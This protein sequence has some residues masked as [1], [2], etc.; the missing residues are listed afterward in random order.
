MQTICLFGSDYASSRDLHLALKRLL[1][2]PDYYGLNADALNDC[3]SDFGRCPALWFRA[4]GPDEVVSAL[5][6]IARVFG[7]NG[8]D[9]KEF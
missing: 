6:L 7:D 2:L 9:V 3:L 8:S 1:S 4:E 5:R